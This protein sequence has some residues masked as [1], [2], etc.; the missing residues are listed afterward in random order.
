[1]IKFVN[2]KKSFDDKVVLDKVSGVFNRGI[3][4]LIVGASGTGKSVLM[5]CIVGL[6]DVNQGR[7][8]YDDTELSSDIT[9]R[10]KI[11]REIGMLFQGGALFDSMNVE[12]N[13]MFPLS[14][15]TDTFPDEQRERANICLKRVGLEN[16]NKKRV[17][18]I[19]GGMKKRVGI[20]RAI[21]NK[22][23]YLFCDEPN[24]GLDPQTA[25]HV[26]EL[27]KEITHEYNTTTVVVSH[28]INSMMTIGE[29]IIF[30]YKG[31]K[32]WEGTSESIFSSSSESFNRFFFSNE[33][34][35][36]IKEQ[37]KS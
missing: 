19:S 4:N 7:V 22:P 9:L 29:H 24:S 6:L 21:V 25:L 35:K 11:R 5:K 28:D 2:I 14:V 23:K 1:M 13:V 17:S 32:T 26:D 37:N 18:E 34:A 16:T 33:M 10:T 27:I 31:H 36:I 15:L 3:V 30:L 20:A 8:Y 12:E